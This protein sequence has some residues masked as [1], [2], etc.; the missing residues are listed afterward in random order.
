MKFI[1]RYRSSDELPQRLPVFPLAGALLLPRAELP[2]SI[3]EPRYL[4][5]VNDA[6]AGDRLIGMIQPVLESEM[7]ERPALMG[8]GCAGRITAYAETPDS[9]I[10][11]TLTG[12]SRFAIREELDTDTAYR[13]VI[14]DFRPF[15]VDL[16]SDGTAAVLSAVIPGL[17]Q[18]Y[19]G[20]FLR[21][22]FWL[23]VTPGLW[24]GS[25]EAD[26]RLAFVVGPDLGCVA[27]E[28]WSLGDGSHCRSIRH[29]RIQHNVP[30]PPV[31]VCDA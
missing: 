27:D 7:E 23:I 19:N 12:V 3:F 25:D 1:D 18:F 24:I 17:G 22:L 13:Q 31:P 8:I 29:C 15:A 11:L 30:P 14:A 4:D 16:V 10:L 9:R 6:M 2:L 20:D 28:D 26:E 21:G 5:M